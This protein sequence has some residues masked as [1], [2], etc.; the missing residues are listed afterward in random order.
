MV[1]LT[2]AAFP[3]KSVGECIEIVFLALVGVSIGAGNFA[4]LAKL[5]GTIPAQIIVFA[6]MV[7]ILALIKAHN[8]KSVSHLISS[9]HSHVERSSTRPDTLHSPC[10]QF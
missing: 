7:Y 2:I 8:I 1:V 5:R 6:I 4:I 9:V 3:G 10:L